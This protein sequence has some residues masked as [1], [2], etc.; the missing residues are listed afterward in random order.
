MRSV[1]LIFS[2]EVVHQWFRC[3]F[4]HLT[5][6]NRDREDEEETSSSCTQEAVCPQGC[7]DTTDK[8]DQKNQL[9]II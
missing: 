3:A 6:H 8:D 5:E 9:A 1:Q 2:N 7:R 4:T